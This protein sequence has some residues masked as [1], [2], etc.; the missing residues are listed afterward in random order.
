[1]EH[2]SLCWYTTGP[3][4]NA[5][6]RWLAYWSA[7]SDTEDPLRRYMEW[8]LLASAT[9][10]GPAKV[11]CLPTSAALGQELSR[12]VL[13]SRYTLLHCSFQHQSNCHK[14]QSIKF[15]VADQRGVSMGLLGYSQTLTRF[16]PGS[17]SLRKSHRLSFSD[18]HEVTGT[19]CIRIKA[20]THHSGRIGYELDA[21]K[22]REATDAARVRNL[23]SSL[24]PLLRR[25]ELTIGLD[26]FLPW[27]LWACCS[28]S[29]LHTLRCR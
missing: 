10:L 24:P 19:S 29:R 22:G 2:N 15:Q 5:G 14:E 11:A 12:A 13:L 4:R 25:R 9:V 17:R 20:H 23:A 8:P 18:G 27:P 3:R 16:S 7:T 1:M 28:P 6:M 26:P 21:D